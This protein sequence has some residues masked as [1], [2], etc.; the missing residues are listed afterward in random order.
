MKRDAAEILK[1]ALSLPAEDRAVLAKA[2][3]DQ[4]TDLLQQRPPIEDGLRSGSPTDS[5]RE[6]W[7]FIS[8]RHSNNRQGR[9]PVGELVAPDA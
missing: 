6:Y 3:A 2:L 7:C 4:P 5:A 1:A 9:A 8:Y